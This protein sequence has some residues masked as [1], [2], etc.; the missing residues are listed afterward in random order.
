MTHQLRGS[1]K[2][3]WIP[4]GASF[5]FNIANEVHQ[6]SAVGKLFLHKFNG[7]EKLIPIC[8]G[9]LGA[10]SQLPQRMRVVPRNRDTVDR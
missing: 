2:C 8:I 6:R 9:S 4:P 1:G 10:L 5:F 7:I 3:S